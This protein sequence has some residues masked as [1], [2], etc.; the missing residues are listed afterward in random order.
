MSLPMTRVHRVP[1]S[2]PTIR[3]RRGGPHGRS[4]SGGLT[5]APFTGSHTGKASSPAPA[6]TSRGH[7]DVASGGHN[8]VSPPM[9][10]TI[11]HQPSHLGR[12]VDRKMRKPVTSSK[13]AK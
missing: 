11:N 12:N 9:P 7:I 13:Q 3:D 5:F 10:P 6:A 2:L 4:R 1:P 8:K